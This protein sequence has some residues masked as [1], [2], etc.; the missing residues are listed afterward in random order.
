MNR[1][2]FSLI[3]LLVVVA[4]IGI[5]SAVG[6]VSYNGYTKNA[7]TIAS[8]ANHNFVVRYL[9]SE[10]MKCNSQQKIFEGVFD[11]I[12]KSVP[13][14]MAKSVSIVVPKKL[15]GQGTSNPTFK[16]PDGTF[17]AVAGAI[18]NTCENVFVC[19]DIYEYSTFIENS[20]TE[21]TVCTCPS[22]ILSEEITSIIPIDPS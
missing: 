1:K 18:T 11:C 15:W 6:V 13:S 9:S 14:T 5:I 19:N 16:H 17:S 21:I 12:D 22:N 2:G 3:E 10:L 8:K 4:I 7:K 20:E